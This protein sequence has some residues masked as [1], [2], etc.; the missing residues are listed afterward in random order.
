MRAINSQYIEW[1]L[2][3]AHPMHW[4]TVYFRG[5]HYGH[6]I[7]NIAESLNAWLLQARDLSIEGMLETIW[8]KLMD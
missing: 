6:L 7:S 8:E 1:L 5:H 4:A 2:D 3:T